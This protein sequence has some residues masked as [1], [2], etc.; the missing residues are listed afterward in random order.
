MFE[1]A[2]AGD[3]PI[4]DLLTFMSALIERMREKIKIKPTLKEDELQISNHKVNM[5]ELTIGCE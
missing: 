4:S 5:R 3:Q 1:V 2:L